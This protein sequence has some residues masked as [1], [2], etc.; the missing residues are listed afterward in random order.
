MEGE[1]A[2]ETGVGILQRQQQIFAV[3]ILYCFVVGV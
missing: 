1:S 3:M 2:N